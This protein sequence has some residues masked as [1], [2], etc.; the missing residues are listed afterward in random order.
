M[1]LRQ[2]HDASSEAFSE[3]NLFTYSLSIV[4]LFACGIGFGLYQKLPA[5]VFCLAAAVTAGGARLWARYALDKVSARMAADRSGLFP[6]DVCTLRVE[7]ENRKWLPLVWLTVRFRLSREGPLLPEHDW[8]TA[9]LPEGENQ[10]AL[11]YEK[12]A[13]FLL[14]YQQAAFPV[15][16]QARRRGILPLNGVKLL[17]GDAL[18]LCIRERE[19]PMERPVELAVFPRLV[20]V[21]TQWFRKNNWE[22]ENGARGFQDDRTVIR[23]VQPYQPGDSAR[24]LNFRLMARGQGA[25]VNRFEKI[26]PRRAAFLLDGASFQALPPEAFEESLEILA[27]LLVQLSR[28]QVAVSLLISPPAGG[29]ETFV[30]CRE[31]RALGEA[32][33]LLAGADTQASLTAEAILNRLAGLSSAFCVCGRADALDPAVCALLA[34]R[35]APVFAWGEQSHPALR[36]MDWRTFRIGGGT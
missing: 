32:L 9:E 29:R 11:W 8:E 31:E 25:M 16:L 28:E 34:R 7:L 17:S 35:R 14:W 30:R 27:S 15:R 20:P 3:T 4:L 19:F 2:E 21:S 12:S 36:V 18:C 23:T 24:N 26:S 13:S 22:L 10:T 33:A 1:K 5:A 6:G